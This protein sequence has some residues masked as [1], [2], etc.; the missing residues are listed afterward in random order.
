MYLKER[1]TKERSESMIRDLIVLGLCPTTAHRQAF[2]SLGLNCHR[3]PEDDSGF[4]V[5][6]TWSLRESILFRVVT[7]PFLREGRILAVREIAKWYYIIISQRSKY[8]SRFVSIT[9]KS[10]LHNRLLE[11]LSPSH[12]KQ[13]LSADGVWLSWIP[14]TAS[15]NRYVFLSTMIPSLVRASRKN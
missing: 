2:A 11:R 10:I 12:R 7:K 3:T 4:T 9:F 1:Q 15:L 14:S 5:R 8:C 6:L 13:Y